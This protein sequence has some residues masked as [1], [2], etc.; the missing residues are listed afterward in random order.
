MYS[1]ICK[2]STLLPLCTTRSSLSTAPDEVS[3]PGPS[4]R[5]SHSLVDLPLPQ[6]PTFYTIR[7][8]VLKRRTVTVESL[9]PCQGRE[10]LRGTNESTVCSR[11][12]KTR[13]TW[14]TPP[15][16]GREI[17]HD[18]LRPPVFEVVDP[19]PH[20][21]TTPQLPR[22]ALPPIPDTSLKPRPP[23][24]GTIRRPGHD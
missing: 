13:V 8:V 19:R 16:H 12:Q 20:P 21:R 14:S 2:R 6:Q 23:S 15:V 22:P 5:G 24:G 3:S 1:P 18:S 10:N 17:F 9:E 7:P 11:T 4:S